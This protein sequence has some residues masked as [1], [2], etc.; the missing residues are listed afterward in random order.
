MEQ[1]WYVQGDP[2]VM[3]QWPNLFGTKEAAE[4]YAREVFPDESEDRRYAR[5]FY[6]V[7]LERE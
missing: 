5:I 4:R 1:V 3:G 7:V 2:D 6:R